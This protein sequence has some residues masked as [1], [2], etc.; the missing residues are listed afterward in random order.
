MMGNGTCGFI[1]LDFILL[2][3][4][5]FHLQSHIV[6]SYLSHF[7]SVCS[8]FSTFFHLFCSLLFPSPCD[9]HNTSPL[10]CSHSLS[11]ARALF[12]ILN[13]PNHVT[14]LW[15][16]YLCVHLRTELKTGRRLFSPHPSTCFSTLNFLSSTGYEPR[17]SR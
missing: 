3:L 4:L 7:F 5:L 15:H 9:T 12:P 6:S 16:V 13:F 8:L 17:V 2:G 14:F 1:E 10:C 11:L